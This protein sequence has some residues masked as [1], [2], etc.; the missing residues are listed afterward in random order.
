VRKVE[1][2]AALPF[3]ELAGF[4]AE[5]RSQQSIAARALEFT[6]LVAARTGEVIGARWS[7]FDV[8]NKTWI[9]PPERMKAHREHRV[10]LASR[11]LAIIQE[12]Q[13]FHGGDDAPVFAGGKGGRQFSKMAF[14]LLLQRMGRR[15]LTTHGFRATFKTWASEQTGFQSEIVEAALAHVIG[16]RVQQAYQRGDMFEKRTRLM[17]Q[18]GKFCGKLPSSPAVIMHSPKFHKS[19]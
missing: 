5:L 17:S 8:H 14:L 12:M 4:L 1:H 18:W 7:E 15:D 16:G 19:D 2:Y 6:I 11:A 10:P 9:V 13:A 3:N